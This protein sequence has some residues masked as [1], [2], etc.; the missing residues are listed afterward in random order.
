[1]AARTNAGM[2]RYSEAIYEALEAEGYE[3]LTDA[4]NPEIVVKNAEDVKESL[5]ITS[6]ELVG[7][8]RQQIADSPDITSE[9]NEK[10]KAKRAKT[11]PERY[12]ERKHLLQ[13]RY[14]LE[15]TPQL[16]AKDDSDWYPKLRNLYY[17]TA[18]RKFLEMKDAKSLDAHKERGNGAV[19]MPDLNKTQMSVSVC[20]LDHLKLTQ[21]LTAKDRGWRAEDPELI[22]LADFALKNRYQIKDALDVWIG[23]KDTPIAIAQK[24]LKTIGYK[25]QLVKREQ[26]GQQRIRVYSSAKPIHEGHEEVFEQ[27]LGRDEVALIDFEAQMASNSNSDQKPRFQL[28]V[29]RQYDLVDAA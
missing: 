13:K 7:E 26:V 1:M 15:V 3:I 8:E 20:A 27:W 29:E 6:E 22:E 24:L 17:L 11:K 21:F 2:S 16:V 18:G 10:L 14:A 19:W 4:D 28:V 9:E 25:L 23:D 12:I 5:K